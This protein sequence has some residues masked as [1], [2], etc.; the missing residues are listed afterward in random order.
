MG[1]VK[2]GNEGRDRLRR[3][4]GGKG[5]GTKKKRRRRGFENL[6]GEGGYID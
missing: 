1:E 5:K 3:G 6:K 2:E 4:D